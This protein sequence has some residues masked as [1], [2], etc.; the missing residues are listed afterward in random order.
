MSEKRTFNVIKIARGSIKNRLAK[1]PLAFGELFVQTTQDDTIELIDK[2]TGANLKKVF[3]GD[4]FAGNGSTT[5]VFLLGSGSALKWNSK[6]STEKTFDEII[7]LC[8]DSPN[9]VFQYDISNTIFEKSDVKGSEYLS[10]NDLIFYN[11]VSD[12][13]VVLHVGSENAV[14]Y[15]TLD[16]NIFTD[17]QHIPVITEEGVARNS[18]LELFET[19]RGLREVGSENAATQSVEFLFN[20]YLES[21]S[22]P[23][24]TTT[25]SENGITFSEGRQIG[26]NLGDFKFTKSFTDVLTFLFEKE[27]N[28]SF[29]LPDYSGELVAKPYVD[30]LTTIFKT[31][32]NRSYQELLKKIND[33]QTKNTQ[34]VVSINDNTLFEVVTITEGSTEENPV[35]AIWY[36]PEGYILASGP[37]NT[38][39]VTNLKIGELSGFTIG[40]IRLWGGKNPP[41]DGIWLLCNG[42]EYD[43][44]QYSDLFEKTGSKYLPALTILSTSDKDTPASYYIKASA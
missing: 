6:I 42:S 41:T 9:N 33:L 17:E 30:A 38:T 8:L 2:T 32:L 15:K 3:K 43:T 24:L 29:S 40:D 21:N 10:K 27:S 37:Q 34:T 39:T 5:E 1:Y 12:Q 19:E 7:Q 14:I 36:Y 11:P 23:A 16:G 28:L 35:V 22:E 31:A 26:V 25:T 13:I 20:S 4:L 44:E 18:K